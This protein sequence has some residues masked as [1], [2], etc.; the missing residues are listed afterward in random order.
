MRLPLTVVK[1]ELSE[2]QLQNIDNFGNLT[3]LK[4]LDLSGN[5]L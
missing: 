4:Y 3:R 5:K 2:N 1:L